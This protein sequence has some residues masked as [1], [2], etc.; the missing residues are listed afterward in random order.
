[1]KKFIILVILSILS[2]SSYSQDLYPRYE[3]DSMGNTIVL[4]TIEQAQKLDNNSDLLLLFKE[5]GLEFN[6][7][8]SIC[9]KAVN[10]KDAVISSQKIEIASLYLLL[11]VKDDK[12][13]TLNSEISEHITKSNIM[14][15]QI[16]NRNSVIK[17]NDKKIRKLKVKM[18]VTGIGGGAVIIGLLYTILS[19]VK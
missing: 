4:M 10:D 13:S 16:D 8:D 14:Q 1:M 9:I 7:Y 19:I 3:K 18:A 11:G 2:I 6:S 17:E 5:A 15:S 12:I